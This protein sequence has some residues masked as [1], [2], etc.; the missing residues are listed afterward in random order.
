LITR[1]DDVATDGVLLFDHHF[2]GLPP[3]PTSRRIVVLVPL[4][5]IA[6]E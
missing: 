6:A 4:K 5:E 1:E 3:H 2:E